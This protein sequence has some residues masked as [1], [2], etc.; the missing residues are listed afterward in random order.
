LAAELVYREWLTPFQLEQI[1]TEKIR[2][3]FYGD[4][5]LS[6][7]IWGG[8]HGR[9]YL[10]RQLRTQ[11]KVALKIIRDEPFANSMAVRRFQRESAPSAR[12]H[13]PNIVHVFMPDVQRDRST[14]SWNT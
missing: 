4:Y 14:S 7:L 3:L 10:A 5:T 12:L 1:E 9:V 8:E 6:N 11:Q 13:H 2:K